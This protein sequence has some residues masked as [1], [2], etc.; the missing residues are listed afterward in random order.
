MPIEIE[1]K[2]VYTVE[3]VAGLFHVSVSTVR[4]LLKAGKL[5]GFR[6]GIQWR[7]WG[8]DL[9]QYGREAETRGEYSPG[10]VKE[11]GNRFDEE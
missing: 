4:R 8:N 1:P 3:D 9:L 10:Y 5:K 2:G 6:V 11:A 7:F